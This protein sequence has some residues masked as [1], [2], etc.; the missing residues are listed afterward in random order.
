M[1]STLI[2]LLVG[3]ALVAYVLWRAYSSGRSA[4]I[5]TSEAKKVKDYDKTIKKLKEAAKAR[6]D[7]NAA[8]ADPEHLRKD[9]GHKRD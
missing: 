3:G 6:D 7:A 5:G 1:N 2:A 9:D 8:N 4:G